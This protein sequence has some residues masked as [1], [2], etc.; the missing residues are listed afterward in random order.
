M[1]DRVMP[2]MILWAVSTTGVLV[3][4][5]WR[6][7]V[8]RHERAGIFIVHGEEPDLEEQEK[9]TKALDRI[10]RW[11]KSLTVISV[12]L[13]LVVGSLWAMDAWRAAYETAK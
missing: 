11:G 6:V 5:I 3:L 12:V 2:W 4:F 1:L 7:M 13:L 8:A 9:V 10:D